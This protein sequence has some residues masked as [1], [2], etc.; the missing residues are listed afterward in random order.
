MDAER[1]V[2]CGE[3]VPEGTMVC[4]NCEHNAPDDH[5]CFGALVSKKDVRDYRISCASAPTE[6]P[7]EF[8]LKMPKVKF[9]GSVSSCVAHAISTTVEY[10]NSLQ[11]NDNEEMSVG[12]I[13]GNRTNTNHTGS[14][15]YVREAIAATCKYGDVKHTLFPYN[16]EV[17]EIIEKFNAVSKELFEKG[18][19]NRFTSYYRLYTADEIK[20]SLMKNG[21]VVFAMPWYKDIRIIN[22]AIITSQDTDAGYHCMVIYGWDE[23]GWKIQNSWSEQW[24]NNGRAILPYDVKIAEA[25]GVIDTL[26]RTDLEVIKPYNS[27]TGK[28]FAKIINA[29]CRI[30]DVLRRC[31]ID[32]TK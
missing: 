22:D 24:A 25:W 32:C 18:E 26:T 19:P 1:C 17:P 27:K 6:F 28:I 29:V 7:K 11:E 15:M 10:F 2:C 5:G 23:R 16:E 14:G 9:Q 3:I 30:F 20:T 4:W 12:Y 8:E 21:P 13:Y 31:H